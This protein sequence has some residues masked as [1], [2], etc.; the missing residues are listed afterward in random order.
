MASGGAD[1][2]SALS[3]GGPS[4]LSWVEGSATSS[5]EPGKRPTHAYRELK[6]AVVTLPSITL[7][8]KQTS[9]HRL[10]YFAN[11]IRKG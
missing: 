6:M 10:F 11:R 7:R 8:G 2:A 9:W 4:V 1:P 5:P 3:T